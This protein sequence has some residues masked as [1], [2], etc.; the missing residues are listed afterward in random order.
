MRQTFVTYD[1]CIF[2]YFKHMLY[3]RMV[4]N[5]FLV[6]WNMI[7]RDT[8]LHG[9]CWPIDRSGENKS[10]ACDVICFTAFIDRL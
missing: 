4:V 5:E 7:Y 8:G 6:P 2:S 1:E 10:G 9:S 3:F